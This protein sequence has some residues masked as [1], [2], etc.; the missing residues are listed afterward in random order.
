MTK[1]NK[2]SKLIE[3]VQINEMAIKLIK[4]RT[5]LPMIIWCPMNDNIQHKQP[6]IKVGLGNSNKFISN[7]FISVSIEREPRYLQALRGHEKSDIISDSWFNPVKKFISINHELLLAHW[8]EKIDDV[9]FGMRIEK[10]IK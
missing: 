2:L 1:I 6:Y 8:N 5:G 10:V 4:E 3:N 7:E 9:E